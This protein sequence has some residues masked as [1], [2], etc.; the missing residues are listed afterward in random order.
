MHFKSEQ[1]TLQSENTKRVPFTFHGSPYHRVSYHYCMF[2][3]KISYN[4]LTF[5]K[6]YQV[7]MYS[8]CL[9]ACQLQ[10]RSRQYPTVWITSTNLILKCSICTSNVRLAMVRIRYV[11]RNAIDNIYGNFK[12]TIKSEPHYCFCLNEKHECVYVLHPQRRGKCD[13]TFQRYKRQASPLLS[14][15]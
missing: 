2:Q 1:R 11:L 9:Y 14:F 3:N 8:S 4:Y 6:S 5:V 7:R 12:H 15:S 10:T 13:I